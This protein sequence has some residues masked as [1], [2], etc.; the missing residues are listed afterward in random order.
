MDIDWTSEN[1]YY[2]TNPRTPFIVKEK[3]KK[4]EEKF[5]LRSHVF[6]T[7]SGS[8]SRIDNTIKFIALKKEAILFASEAANKHIHCSQRDVILNTLPYFHIGGLAAYSRSYLSGAK[9]IDL[10]SAEKKWDPFFFKNQLDHE[11]PTLTSLVPAQVFDLVRHH[12]KPNPALRA[13]IVGGASLSRSL[14]DQADQLG[15]PLLPSYG[16]TECCSQIAT[17]EI[18]FSWGSSLF[19]QLKILP[20]LRV[21]TNYRK[22]IF[23]FG[24]SLFTGYAIYKDNQF[25]FLKPE[26]IS[27]NNDESF[28]KTSDLGIQES[29]YLYVFGRDDDVIQIG[30]ENVS[31]SRLEDIFLSVTQKLRNWDHFALFAQNDERLGKRIVLVALEELCQQRAFLDEL[32][33][34]FNKK[35]FPFEKIREIVFVEFIPRSELGKLKRLQLADLIAA[36][37]DRK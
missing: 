30:G 27:S 11:Q 21:S 25:S 16:M 10:Y 5:L 9:L 4:L 29:D 34:Q 8:T 18:G 14:F 35:V 23:V 2:F 3:L 15:W 19:P 32:I 13:V 1:S 6:L 26:K 33:L 24:Q 31:L 12:L 22:E 36:K 37:N 28:F 7:S 20:H 17:A